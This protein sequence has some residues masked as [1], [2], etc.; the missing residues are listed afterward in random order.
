MQ[1]RDIFKAFGAAARRNREATGY[2][3][4]RWV[5][6]GDGSY[7]GAIIDAVSP[8]AS[9]VHWHLLTDNG[10]GTV[11][12]KGTAI[13]DAK[14]DYLYDDNTAFDGMDIWIAFPPQNSK[15]AGNY[16]VCDV[17]RTSAAS[18]FGA[19][20]LGKQALDSAGQPAVA[21]VSTLR[22]TLNSDLTITVGD[23]NENYC[24][25]AAI[26]LSETVFTVDTIDLSSL[27]A[28]LTGS[29]K[30]QLCMVCLDKATNTLATLLTT[31]VDHSAPL[32]AHEELTDDDVATFD[33]LNHPSYEPVIIA[34]LYDGQTEFV[35]DD[36]IDLEVRTFFPPVKAYL[37]LKDKW[38][39]AV[40][41]DVTDDEDSNYSV[42]SRWYDTTNDKEYV[43]LDATSGAAVWKETTTPA[44]GPGSG[45]VTSVALTAS[46]SG[47]FDVSGSPITGA[48]TLALSMDD[49]N[50]NL[51]LAGP[52]TGAA[53][54]PAFRALVA[55]DLPLVTL[56]KGGTGVDLSAAGPGFLKQATLGANVTVA[57][58]DLS[59]GDVTGVLAAGRFPAL[60]G[61]VTTVAGALATTLA[62]VNSNVG[63][64]ALATVTVNAKGLVTAASA[65]ATTGSGNV[66][67]ATSPTLTTPTI[68]DFTNATHNHQNAAGGG[69]LDAAAIASGTLAQARTDYAP[70]VILAPGSSTRNVIQPSG[71]FKALI[72]KGNASQTANLMEWQN[73][74]GTALV[75]IRAVGSMLLQATQSAN[76]ADLLH[77]TAT[78]DTAAA[79][80]V[81]GAQYVTVASHTSGTMNS[82]QGQFS[83]SLYSG[84]SAASPAVNGLYGAFF[85]T[86]IV[87]TSPTGVVTDAVGFL[88][89]V[90]A[91]LASGSPAVTFTN[92]YGIR[93]NN[94][95]KTS[96]AL[97]TTNSYGIYIAAQSGATNLSYALRSDGG[98]IY[99][100]A[101]ATIASASGAVW[102]GVQAVGATA[103]ITGSTN[104]TT[105]AGFNYFRLGSP[106]LSAASA[107]TVTY[108]ATFY[109]ANPPTGGGA[110]PVTITNAYALWVDN[111]VARFDS[112]LDLSNA[113]V[114]LVLDSTTGTKIGTATSQKLALWNATPVVQP[115]TAIGAATRVGGGGAALTDTDTF[116]GYTVA[117]IVKLLRTIGAAA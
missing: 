95:G 40:A 26:T 60:T 114:N 117:Q 57:A 6:L 84:T 39:G 31:A 35:D 65:A 17:D 50:A 86:G 79:G 56:A 41:P 92:Q 1:N 94:Q 109:I 10:T 68:A 32:P 58:V 54:Q 67:L 108:A 77:V 103:T 19:T 5:K 48:G 116:D 20:P 22:A 93:I 52:T 82:V 3:G 11:Q 83:Q 66:V 88:L 36:A 104:I 112:N 87:G 29:D 21:Q 62:T 115:T 105:A 12:E 8:Q 34:Y 63:S 71:D 70:A 99:I 101:S 72:V 73:S 9:A 2:T 97:T 100:D 42:G 91:N 27:I 69:T 30:H 43:C 80:T 28:D 111:G 37:A 51:V 107:L 25:P 75:T 4:G 33:L 106:T 38:N 16:Y 18:Q 7:T 81:Y 78:H 110:G 14:F 53:A 13:L 24:Y 64:F 76:N 45:S 15:A 85:R 55:A 61:D 90:P 44:S 102:N 59:T 113:A 74:G 49:Q 96:T 23:P 47:I 46:P 89:D 98:Y